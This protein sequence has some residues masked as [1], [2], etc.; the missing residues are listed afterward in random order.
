MAGR[1]KKEIQLKKTGRVA[2]QQ[3]AVRV[4]IIIISVI[5]ILSWI[6]SLVV[7]I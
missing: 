3:T 5:V 2:R 1:T 4:V 6:L 7:N